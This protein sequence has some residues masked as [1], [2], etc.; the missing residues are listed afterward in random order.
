[1]SVKSQDEGGQTYERN[2][3]VKAGT[4]AEAVAKMRAQVE[5]MGGR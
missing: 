5:G 4:E 3:S 2:Y 1:M